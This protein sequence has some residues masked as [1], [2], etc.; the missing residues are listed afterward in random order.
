MLCCG[1]AAGASKLGGIGG[2]I[3]SRRRVVGMLEAG[4]MLVCWFIRGDVLLERFDCWYGALVIV[5]WYRSS[6]DMRSGCFAISVVR[7]RDVSIA[8]VGGV[9]LG[10]LI[11]LALCC[12]RVVVLYS[13]SSSVVSAS[14]S[15]SI[16]YSSSW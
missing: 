11:G 2:R 6:R 4:G 8:V 14:S 3:G 1:S 10:R 12:G 15:A 5:C 13:S 16:E 7:T 9:R